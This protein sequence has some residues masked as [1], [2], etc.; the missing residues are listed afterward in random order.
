MA[1]TQRHPKEP[2][3][4]QEE[5]PST[6]SIDVRAI[7][8]RAPKVAGRYYPADPSELRRA[9]QAL[10]PS[11]PADRALG[12]VVPHGPLSYCGAIAAAAFRRMAVDETVV[13]LAP[14]HA[15]R[16]PRAAIVS[17]GAFAIPGAVVPIDERLAESIR[18]LGGLSDAANVF[19]EE[20]AVEAILP[21]LVGARPRVSIVPIALHDISPISAARIGSAIADAIVGRGGGVTVVATTDLVHYVDPAALDEICLP[22]LGRI[23]A[24]DEDGVLAIT[25]AME[26]GPGPIL[27]MC[28]LGALLTAMHALRALG[29]NVGEICARGSSCEVDGKRA[30]AVGYGA[31][32]FAAR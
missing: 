25:R 9:V 7:G 19:D 32:A 30:F 24:L 29:A 17:E 23:A 21:L 18:A 13:I 6:P 16:G 14:N 31:L 22:L 12:L 4:G 11:H 3:A 2:R 27:E 26:N 28:G 10:V 20:H 1:A 15:A 8:V 5:S